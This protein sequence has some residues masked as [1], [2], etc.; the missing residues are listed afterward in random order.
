MTILLTT[1]DTQSFFGVPAPCLRSHRKSRAV[2]DA[3][4]GQQLCRCVN[5]VFLVDGSMFETCERCRAEIH[6]RRPLSCRLKIRVQLTGLSFIA[7]RMSAESTVYDNY[8]LLSRPFV[9]VFIRV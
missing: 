4:L 9:I 2:K 8:L 5:D 6:I 7:I 3:S 1:E